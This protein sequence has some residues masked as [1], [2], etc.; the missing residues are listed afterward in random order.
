[1]SGRRREPLQRKPLQSEPQ[2][3]EPRQREHRQER[4]QQQQPAA[5]LMDLQRRAGNSTVVALLAA[6]QAKLQVGA[7]DDP[8]EREADAVARR[9]VAALHS[10][11]DRREA[12]DE[13]LGAGPAVSRI[14]RR[15]APEVGAAG[16]ELSG[17]TEA[18]IDAA[19]S[20]GRPLEPEMRS[21]FEQAFGADLS[22]VRLHTGSGSAAL[23][24][25]VAARAFTV[26]SDIFLGSG[27]PDLGSTAG[28]ELLAHELTH[29]IQQRG[30]KPD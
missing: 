10:G 24:D 6:G 22:E 5:P 12:F 28:Q 11:V 3:S 19:R 25:R 29:T 16:G 1:M 26:G 4:Q 17:D 13:E 27:T 20:G 23:N 18:A 9:V 7:A 30:G 8:Y 2:Q 14:Q 15:A 21:G